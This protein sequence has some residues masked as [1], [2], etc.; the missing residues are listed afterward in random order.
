MQVTFTELLIISY[1]LYSKKRVDNLRRAHRVK[2]LN[3]KLE[4]L[5]IFSFYKVPGR[6]TESAI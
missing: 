5:N 2:S 4:E 6:Y 3:L 1:D